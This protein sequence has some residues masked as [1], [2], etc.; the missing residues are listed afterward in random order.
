M[1]RVAFLPLFL[2]AACFPGL[3]SI[4]PGLLALVPPEAKVVSG[5]DVERA[6]SSELGDRKS[7]V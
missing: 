1:R 4:D 3:A 2:S 7:V 6:Q 5:I